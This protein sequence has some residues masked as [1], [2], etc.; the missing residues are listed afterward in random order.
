MIVKYKF[1]IRK[2]GLIIKGYCNKPD[3]AGKTPT[4]IMSHEFSANM[5]S[6]SRYTRRLCPL[7]YLVFIFNFCD[8]GSGKSTGRKSTDMSM[9]TE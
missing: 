1:T 9:I 4:I 2:D 3:R 7:G 5:L 8:S 6:I